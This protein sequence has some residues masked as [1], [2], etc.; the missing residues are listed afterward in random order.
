MKLYNEPQHIAMG[1]YEA[2]ISQYLNRV[3]T[4]TGVLA[5]LTMGSVGAPGLSDI[6]VIVVVTDEFP[7]SE[8]KFLSTKHIDDRLFLHGPVVI[9]QS[10][11]SELQFLIYASNLKLIWGDIEIPDFWLL[12]EESKRYLA[13]SYLIDFTESRFQQFALLNA[14]G[15]VDK[16]AWLTRIWSLTHTSDLFKQVIA[17]Q[18]SEPL[19][20]MVATVKKPRETWLQ[21]ETI[22]DSD[23]LD[24]LFEAESLNKKF[25]VNTLE[26][27][28]GQPKLETKFKL[29]SGQKRMQF[30]NGCSVSYR[31]DTFNFLSKK[32]FG[33]DLVYPAAYLAHLAAYDKTIKVNWS[34]PPHVNDKLI[35]VMSK[36]F[37]IV[38]KHSGWVSRH[39]K[40]SGSMLGY[41][42][43]APPQKKIKSL[44]KQILIRAYLR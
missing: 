29:W 30:S 23:F 39:A 42:G 31:M 38:Q 6:D 18:L 1:E 9:P 43:T 36:R 24:S 20:R 5:V 17:N 26:S 4:A 35:E 40:F 15:V 37:S 8:S 14:T 28:W 2:A 41:L 12:P 22:T 13:I 7:F 44:I 16:R 32:I 19:E 33:F 27:V 34:N 3:T 10:M 25:F 21:Q 11:I